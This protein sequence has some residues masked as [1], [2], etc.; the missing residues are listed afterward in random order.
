[1]LAETGMVIIRNAVA[2]GTEEVAG[3]SRAAILKDFLNENKIIR[4]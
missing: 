2:C 1:L 4:G 3:F